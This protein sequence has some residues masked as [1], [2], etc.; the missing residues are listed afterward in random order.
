M[1]VIGYQGIGKSTLAARN[2]KYID[3]ESSNFWFDDPETKQRVR[4][5]NWYEMYF[6]VAE[7]LS[8]QGYVVFVSY[9]LKFQGI[10]TPAPG[11]SELY[12]MKDKNGDWMIHN[13]ESDED[14]QE[15][16]EKTR[17]EKDVQ[18]LIAQ[19][20]EQYDQALESDE[21]LSAY[22]AQLGEETNTALMADDGEMLTASQDCNVRAEASTAS[23]VL[24]RLQAGD[25]VKKLENTDN[26][27]IK[28]EYKGEEAYVH[29]DLLQ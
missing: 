25:Q 24:G 7:D 9:D 6:N 10:D 8:R 11:L 28:I 2:L 29:A 1:I 4:H 13:D 5:S 19:Q 17:Q 27:W 26:G 21:E 20:E 16:L 15:C 12:V 3:L 18:E 22:L 14:V 23:K